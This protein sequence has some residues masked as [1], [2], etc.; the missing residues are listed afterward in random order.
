MYGL[1]VCIEIINTSNVQR[2]NDDIFINNNHYYFDWC[3]IY[4]RISIN[5]IVNDNHDYGD[6]DDDDI[7]L[8]LT[9]LLGDKEQKKKKK[10]NSS[11]Q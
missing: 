10:K 7:A 11:I 1:V 5:N 2:P 6:N 3:R 8:L 4:I 9:Y